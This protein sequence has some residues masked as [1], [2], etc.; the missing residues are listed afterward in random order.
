[1]K[2]YHLYIYC[3]SFLISCH[4]Q[5]TTPEMEEA[6]SQSGEN[7]EELFQ[8]LRYYKEKGDTLKKRAAEYLLG[9]MT[10]HASYKSDSLARNYDAIDSALASI[11]PGNKELVWHTVD[12]M[13]SVYGSS[14]IQV[15]RD[16]QTLSADFIIQDI[17]EAFELWEKSPWC[18]HLDFDDFC[19]YL[20]P[21][22][23]IDGYWPFNREE[24]K[25]ILIDSDLQTYLSNTQYSSE[26]R[27]S[28]FWACMAVNRK[29]KELDP[30]HSPNQNI[31]V[32]RL[33]TRSK[34]PAGVC[35]EYAVIT[36]AAMRSLGIPVGID[37]T[38]QWP[39]R[40][41][42]HSWNVLLAN[43][44]KTLAFGGADTNPDVL[45]K[46]DAKM[47]K[48][49]RHTYAAN[50][51]IIRLLRTEKQVP[52]ALANPHCKDVTTEYMRTS[53]VSIPIR[54]ERKHTYAYLAVFND[55]EWIPVCFGKRQDND[56]FLFEHIGRDIAYLPVYYEDGKVIPFAEPF[57]LDSKGHTRF[58]K[59]DLSRTREVVL[60]R[61]YYL[62]ERM[63]RY[64]GR[65]VGAVIEASNKN[66]FSDADTLYTI[67]K[68]TLLPDSMRIQSDKK[69]RYWRYVSLP[70]TW[71]NIAELEFRLGDKSLMGDIIGT[72]GVYDPLESA[73]ADKYSVF[74]KDPLTF[75]DAPMDVEYSWVGMDFGSPVAIDK[76]MYTPR[77]DDNNI[78]VGDRYELFYWDDGGWHSL[79]EQEASSFELRYKCI[80]SNA[81]FLLKDHSRGKEERIFT[82]ENNMQCWW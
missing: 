66:D 18:Q 6:F 9:N 2:N 73:T 19:E 13:C 12:S 4:M 76:I 56:Y 68:F 61:K 17:E 15:E 71:C 23:V 43:S 35:D 45:H 51:E 42:G 22:R 81:L 24:I 31:P 11:D 57:I 21:Y 59:P 48:V 67:Q 82:Y 5:E 80:P 37:F 26:M 55:Q 3:L 50:P 46:P 40:S 53:D 60:F 47:A 70:G 79:G 49:Y 33:S 29:L 30:E 58:L 32:F 64:A 25:K 7:R 39:F 74:D 34:I 52:Q 41:L 16:I 77:N 65:C 28:A 20:L 1:M 72:D 27:N 63:F 75:F 14:G 54:N 8:V 69:Y 44:G 62:S 78:R 38:P 36:A 10:Y